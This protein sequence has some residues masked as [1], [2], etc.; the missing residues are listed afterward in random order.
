MA[1]S[2]PE[3][4][5][6]TLVPTID[7]DHVHVVMSGGL[8]EIYVG[9]RHV[10]VGAK[11]E[12]HREGAWHPARVTLDS[13]LDVKVEVLSPHWPGAP[14][15]LDPSDFDLIAARVQVD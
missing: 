9:E 13:S 12:L 11:I 3:S 15:R 10:P 14:C 4:D 8:A 1:L 6:T 5:A 2:T 7:D